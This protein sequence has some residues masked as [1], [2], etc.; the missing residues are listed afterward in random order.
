MGFHWQNLRARRSGTLLHGRAWLGRFHVEW[1]VPTRHV[2]LSVAVNGGDDDNTAT[3]FVGCWLFAIWFGCSGLPVGRGEWRPFGF[4][5]PDGRT[6]YAHREE[7]EFSLRVHDWAIWL[8][9]WGSTME[10][11][12]ADPWWRKG[13]TWHLLDALLGKRVHVHE[14]LEPWRPVL[15]PM[16]EGCHETLMR[17]EART[18]K[19]ARWPWWPLTIRQE[20]IEIRIEKGI[21][22]EGKGES[23]YDC[24]EDGLFGCSSSSFSYE[25]A[26]AHVVESVLTSRKRYGG[27]WQHREA[28]PVL[29]ARARA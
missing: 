13:V 15:V 14:V 16:P 29:A 18:W 28:A 25:K 21:P 10:W 22:F 19:R 3:V 6:G 11:R 4:T 5:T 2:G 12:S 27:S 7:R 8:T 24:G 9:V 26:I 23:G 1:S 20:Y 17:P